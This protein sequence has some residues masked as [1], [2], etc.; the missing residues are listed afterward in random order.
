MFDVTATHHC[1]SV[2]L[3]KLNKLAQPSNGGIVKDAL[4]L[5]YYCLHGGKKETSLLEVK[6]NSLILTT[7]QTTAIEWIQA[8]SSVQPYQSNL[9]WLPVIFIFQENNLNNA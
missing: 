9:S 5:Q 8:K 3:G 1:D 7:T 2:Q 6:W 4:E